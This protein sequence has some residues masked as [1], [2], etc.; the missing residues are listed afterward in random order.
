MSAG[1]DHPSFLRTARDISPPV[2]ALLAGMFVNKLGSF[3]QVFLVLLLVHRGYS[4]ATAG[5]ALGAYGAGAIAGVVAG[6][7][8]TDR[9]GYRW[10]IAGSMAL[11]AV[12]TAALLVVGQPLIVLLVSAAIGATAQAY[13]PA[14][15]AMLSELTPANQQVMV[16]AIYRLALN[17]GMTAGPL[18]GVLLISAS[19]D[20]LLW[21]DAATSLAFAVVAAALLGRPVPAAVPGTGVAGRRG[22]AGLLADRR[23]LLVLAALFVSQVVYIQY[24]AVLPLHLQARGVAVQ[25]YGG[26]VSLNALVVICCEVPITQYVQRLPARVA[27]MLGMGLIGAGLTL[28][29]LPAGL[30]GLVVATLVWSLGETIGSPAVSAYPGQVAPPDLRGRYMAAAGASAQLGYAVGPVLGVAAWAGLGAGVW[31]LCG[32][33]TILAVAGIGAGMRPP[34]RRASAPAFTPASGEEAAP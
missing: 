17:L 9:V 32:L 7:S 10:T 22:Y 4:S 14:S 16:F 29:L 30:A 12:L 11:A 33:V 25:V 5:L 26:L 20:L 19:Y 15:S 1:P 2:W 8:V 24:L 21:V 3:V 28:Y 18:L 34:I 23:F 31:A 6:G 13:R 27:V